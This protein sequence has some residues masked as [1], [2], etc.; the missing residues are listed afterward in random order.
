MKCL[1]IDFGTTN[2]AVAFFDNAQPQKRIISIPYQGAA[3]FLMKKTV[4]SAVYFDEQGDPKY[5]G[6]AAIEAGK[7]KPHLLVDKIKRIIGKT[8]EVAKKDQLL[9]KIAYQIVPGKVVTDGG[10]S[11]KEKQH[12]A[13][14][15]VGELVMKLYRPEEIAAMILAEAKKDAEAYLKA[16]F[17]YENLDYDFIVITFPANFNVT[18]REK[19]EQAAGMAG[20]N[21]ERLLFVNEPTAAAFDAVF[22]G[23]IV[24]KPGIGP[25]KHDVLVLNI[26]S[27]TTD[28]ALVQ[29]RS[30]MKPQ[31]SMTSSRSNL[32][33]QNRIK[34]RADT[35]ATG[36]N[37]SLGGTD[38][39]IEIVNWVIGQLRNKP[40]FN[41]KFAP[42]GRQMLRFN[43]EDAKISI[44]EGR[45]RQTRILIPGFEAMGP[46]LDAKK[47][48]TIA[49]SVAS[50]CIIEY[51]NILSKT[52]IQDSNYSEIILT[53]GPMAMGVV[54]TMVTSEF[55]APIFSCP[56]CSKQLH[57]I[58]PDDEFIGQT[59]GLPDDRKGTAKTNAW[60]YIHDLEGNKG[61]EPNCREHLIFQD[62]THYEVSNTGS[63]DKIE[64]TIA[65]A[66]ALQSRNHTVV[67]G[68]PDDPFDP[69]MCVAR[70][71]AIS[72]LIEYTSTLPHTIRVLV[73]G[74][75]TREVMKSIIELD[76]QLPARLH[77]SWLLD[78][79]ECHLEI[80]VLQDIDE[81]NNETKF[82]SKTETY[83][84]NFAYWGDTEYALKPSGAEKKL[85]FAIDVKT[86]E[87]D[88]IQL[89]IFE[90]ESQ[91]A[92]W[93]MS[94][95]GS[96]GTPLQFRQRQ[97]PYTI[98]PEGD[99]ELQRAWS[100]I[101]AALRGES[102]EGFKLIS[103]ATD[104]FRSAVSLRE[105]GYKLSAET[106]R[107]VDEAWPSFGPI[108]F[109]MRDHAEE[110]KKQNLGDKE[111]LETSKTVAQAII[112]D[113][114][115]YPELEKVMRDNNWEAALANM[116]ISTEAI[117]KLIAKIEDAI[118]K[119]AGL[120]QKAGDTILR[121]ASA[122]E[123]DLQFLK[124]HGNQEILLKSEEGSRFIQATQRVQAVLT[125]L[126]AV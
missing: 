120:K 11:E 52:K 101:W 102:V 116:A 67:E 51:N 53:G 49:R 107:L 91:L 64:C 75:N 16:E 94:P 63:D 118:G 122:L 33:A 66:F 103:D 47:L 95:D 71:A 30:I 25:K 40:D 96:Q 48:N 43:A 124:A 61:E 88:K 31:S 90:N 4:P 46:I 21:K 3:D 110:F 22:E 56:T 57:G 121:L 109:Y 108:Y 69:M 62:G 89:F 125:N 99:I 50:K 77:E 14:V 32:N 41:E 114:K 5:Y 58:R 8:Y 54:R 85:F 38:M 9:E 113:G 97:G 39:D 106:T 78:P 15:R 123:S 119:A 115:F 23:K 104:L 27:G 55:I 59:T 19:I 35:V 80:H 126:N 36:G 12:E 60:L 34:R 10:E 13:L 83:Y 100:A 17:G 72:P 24:D 28:L 76:T 29:L 74:Q 87:A 45:C 20:F 86:P 111:L 70:G 98:K 81:E 117:G 84:G 65:S 42:A 105:D 2:T 26:G 79:W 93:L 6:E 68:K 44:S 18:Q 1:G 37:S 112:H 82:D 73:K 7:T 92:N